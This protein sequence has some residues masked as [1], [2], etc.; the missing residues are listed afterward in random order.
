MSL[1][2]CKKE[3]IIPNFK[4]ELRPYAVYTEPFFCYGIRHHLLY[5][6][7]GSQNALVKFFAAFVV[8]PQNLVACL[9]ITIQLCGQKSCNIIELSDKHTFVSGIET[10]WGFPNLIYLNRLLDESNGFIHEDGSI[11]LNVTVHNETAM[12]AHSNITKIIWNCWE[13]RNSFMYW[14]PEEVVQTIT[15]E[16]PLCSLLCQDLVLKNIQ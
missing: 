5:F 14:I 4:T 8:V 11:H 16:L 6:P 3:F 1:F 7:S 9:H 2:S 13:N 15:D 12:N 10:D